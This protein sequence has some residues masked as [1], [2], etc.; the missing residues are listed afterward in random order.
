MS[1]K[2]SKSPSE[3]LCSAIVEG[4]LEN[5]ANE[6]VVLDLR[7]LDGAITEFFVIC[8]GDSDTHVDGISNS[9]DR[10]VR[11]NLKEKPWN[12]EGKTNSDWV[13]LDYV[14][15]VG[16]VFYKEKRPFYDIEELWSDATRTNIPS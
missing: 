13:L 6:I 1:K 11:K 7:E 8:S 15:V 4:M 5:K 14:N 12:I 16:H 10:Y 2:K 9:I 3:I